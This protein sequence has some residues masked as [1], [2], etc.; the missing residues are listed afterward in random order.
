[1]TEGF[2]LLLQFHPESQIMNRPE[3]TSEK[4]SS[5]ENCSLYII[6]LSYFH[7]NFILMKIVFTLFFLVQKPYEEVIIVFCFLTVSERLLIT[8]IT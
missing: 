3:V 6:K 8:D 1:M 4:K 7:D 5:S 2:P